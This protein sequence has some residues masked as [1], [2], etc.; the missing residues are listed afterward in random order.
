VGERV[1]FCEGYRERAES[2]ELFEQSDQL[3]PVPQCGE[4]RPL[5]ASAV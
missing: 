3:E 2:G 1:R 5:G 4:S